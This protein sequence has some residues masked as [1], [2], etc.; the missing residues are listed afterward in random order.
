MPFSG[1]IFY[2]YKLFIISTM[3][4]KQVPKYQISEKAGLIM[5]IMYRLSAII[6]MLTNF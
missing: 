4:S 5:A 3:M 2:P 6:I 1:F